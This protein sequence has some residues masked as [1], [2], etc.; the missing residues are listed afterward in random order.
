M[1][2]EEIAEAIYKFYPYSVLIK[3]Q[4]LKCWLM[5]RYDRREHWTDITHIVEENKAKVLID[6]DGQ[7]YVHNPKM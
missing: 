7:I 5:E 4:R 1:S 3:K 2:K 6:Y